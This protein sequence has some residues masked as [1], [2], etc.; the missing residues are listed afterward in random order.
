MKEFHCKSMPWQGTAQLSLYMSIGIFLA[1]G[2]ISNVVSHATLFPFHQLWCSFLENLLK[3][4]IFTSV[5]LMTDIFY[6]QEFLKTFETRF[7]EISV[8][9]RSCYLF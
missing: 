8:A 2:T 5:E 7:H 1:L 9:Y 4:Y 3:T 6:E